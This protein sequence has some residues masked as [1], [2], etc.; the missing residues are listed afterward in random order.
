MHIVYALV[1]PRTSE[2]RYIGKSSTGLER[3]RSH[4]EP[5]RISSDPNRHKA[6]WIGALTKAGL[7]PIITVLEECAS[8]AAALVAEVKWI[9]HGRAQGWR[10]TNLTD[11]GDGTAGYR[12]SAETRA[13]LSAAHRGFKHAP[14]SIEKMR[15][16][17]L[18]KPR[19]D[20]AA[21]HKTDAAKA[22]RARLREMSVGRA[23]PDLAARNMTDEKRALLSRKLKGRVFSE[24]TIA[25]M[26]LAQQRRQAAIRAKR[27]SI[28]IDTE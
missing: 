17:K 12:P 18:G 8:D 14:E 10:L 19:P 21:W 3:P 26:R 16:A 15:Q 1:D 6:G 24:E 2:T 28:G 9:A 25:R 5:R 20:M 22:H 23:R 13:K 11:G 4:F 7:K 27:Q